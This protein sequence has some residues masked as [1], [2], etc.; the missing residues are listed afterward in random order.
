M[1]PSSLLAPVLALAPASAMA[2]SISI[3]LSRLSVAELTKAE[4]DYIA[5]LSES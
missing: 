4:F 2:G 1:K 3:D 5:K